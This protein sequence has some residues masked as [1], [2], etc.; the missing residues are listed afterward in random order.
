MEIQWVINLTD[1]EKYKDFIKKYEDHEV[2]KK[3]IAKNINHF[4]IE[5]CQTSFWKSLIGCLLTTQQNSRKDSPVDKFLKSNDDLLDVNYCLKTNDLANIAKTT[6]KNKGLRRNIHIASE[7][8]YAVNWLKEKGWQGL[9]SKLNSISSQTTI[10]KERAVARYLRYLPK[11]QGFKGLGQKQ[12][13]NLI[14]MMGLSKYVIPLDSRMV[15][16]LPQL[17]FPVPLGSS[18]LGNEDYYCFIED[19]IQQIMK[20]IEIHPCVFD[21]CVFASLERK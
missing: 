11:K 8:E 4:N 17:G 13:R 15:K 6:L 21:A 10:E 19:G 9:E 16:V 20:R 2:V 14:Q 12:S 1:E 7:I 3:R 5:I 18:A